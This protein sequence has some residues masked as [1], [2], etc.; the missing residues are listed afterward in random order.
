[1][2][3]AEKV[4]K[5]MAALDTMAEVWAAQTNLLRNVQVLCAAPD[6]EARIRAFI[7]Q[8]YAEGLYEGRTSHQNVT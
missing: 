7:K 2:T 3:D 6:R 4:A 1:M 8:A 5:A